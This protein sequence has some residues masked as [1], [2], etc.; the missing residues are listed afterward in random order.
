MEVMIT[1][2]T[3]L[4]LYPYLL[5]PFPAKFAT[6]IPRKTFLFVYFDEQSEALPFLLRVMYPRPLHFH[7]LECLSYY[8]LFGLLREVKEIVVV[9]RFFHLA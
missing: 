5:F 9:L 2:S 1:G 4:H 6:A 8:V 3:C 7:C